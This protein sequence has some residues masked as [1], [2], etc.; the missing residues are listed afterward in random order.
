[1]VQLS[2]DGCRSRVR[3]LTW[4]IVGLYRAMSVHLSAI[5]CKWPLGAKNP[6]F[7]HRLERFLSIPARARREW[8][9]PAARQWSNEAATTLGEIRLV[10][11]G[12]KVGLGHQLL[13]VCLAFRRRAVPWA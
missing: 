8:Y 10:V 1:L 5:V 9:E 13:I 12:T 3:N 11:D 6:S 4:L 2:P 7:W